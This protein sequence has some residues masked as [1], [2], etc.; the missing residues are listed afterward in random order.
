[1][2][3]QAIAKAYKRRILRGEITINDVPNSIKSEVDELLNEE[4]EENNA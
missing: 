1:M 2:N 3:L 4:S